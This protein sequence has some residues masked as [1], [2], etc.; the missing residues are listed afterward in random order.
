MTAKPKAVMTHGLVDPA[1][2]AVELRLLTQ[3]PLSLKARQALECAIE[4]LEREDSVQRMLLAM[5]HHAKAVRR[6]TP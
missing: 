6:G 3:K 4:L 5:E 2:A 1:L